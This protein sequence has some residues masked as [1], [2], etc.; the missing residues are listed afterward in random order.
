MS[1][2]RRRLMMSIKKQNEYTELN[3]IEGTGTQYINTEVKTKQSLKIEC[4]FSG[5]QI[6]TLLF[7]A[8]KTISFDG[9]VWGFNN[10]DSVFSGFG[11]NTQKNNTTV[12]TIDDKKHTVVLSNEVYTIDGIDQV[13]PNRGTFTE[14]Y[15]IYLFTWNNANSADYRCFQGKVYEFKIYDNNILIRNMIPVLDK[16]GIACMYD[17]VNRKYYYNQGTGEFLY[18]VPIPKGFTYKEGTKD[19][20]LVIQ[21]EKGNEFVWVPVTEKSTYAKDFGFKSNFNATSTNTKDD[22]LPNGITDETADVKKYGGFYIGRYEAG[23]PEN[24]TT[25]DG[26]SSSTSNVEGIPVS[27]KGATVWG[28]IGYTNAKVSAEKMINN[29]YVQTGLL[30]G[31]AWDTTCHWIEDSLSSINASA[32]LTDSRYYGN[33]KNSESP[34]NVAGY[35]KKQV[36][37]YSDKWM[38]KN[39][40]DLAGNAWEWTSEAYSSKFIFRGGCF[41]D[42]G[43]NGPVSYR[44]SSNASITVSNLGFRVRLYIK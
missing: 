26:K 5:N 33:F 25:I 17:K 21:D 11:G 16:N 43:S 36:A 44:N 7:G 6:A 15:N 32:S 2:F 19:T 22:T 38:V 23:V 27:K 3:Y 29:E 12:N 20:G 14:F 1:N 42:G 39:I 8:R 34:A 40:Y 41:Y 28:S 18:G 35:G 37:G 24:Q 4:T 31:K 13:L 9:L 30:T 10:V